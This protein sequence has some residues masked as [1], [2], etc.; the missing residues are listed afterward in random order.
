MMDTEDLTFDEEAAM[1]AAQERSAVPHPRD[2]LKI[3][4]DRILKGYPRNVAL[5]Q[6]GPEIEEMIMRD[7]E[8]LE[9]KDCKSMGTSVLQFP[10]RPGSE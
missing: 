2:L 4:H 6:W 5:E 1:E 3:E 7:L 10:C 9:R 8:F